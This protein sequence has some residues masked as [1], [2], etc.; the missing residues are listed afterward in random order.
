VGIGPIAGGQADGYDDDVGVPRRLDRC[1]DFLNAMA[2]RQRG[3]LESVAGI[4]AVNSYVHY[5]LGFQMG[6]RRRGRWG[7]RHIQGHLEQ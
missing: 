7:V 5:V 3:G 4:N 2:A 6:Y 1:P